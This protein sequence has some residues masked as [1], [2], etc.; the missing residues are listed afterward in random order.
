MKAVLH[1]RAGPNFRALI[2]S[3]RGVAEIVV[4]DPAASAEFAR[5]MAEAEIL[6]HVLSPVT[7][8][9]MD[10]APH[11]MLVQKIG[12]GVD[13]IDRVHA[14]RRGIAVCNMPGTNTAAVAEMTLSLI[15]ACLR[16]LTELSQA[17]RSGQGW[18]IS[19]S[20]GDGVGELAG[21]T[22]G[23]V[24]YGAVARRLVPV[25]EALGAHPVVHGRRPNS[26]G[27]PLLPLDELLAKSDIVS[28]HLPATE[29]TAGIIDSRRI[30]LMKP[31]AILVNT[32]RGSLVDEVALAHALATGHLSAAGLDVFAQ[33]PPPPGNPLL[34]LSNVVATPHI[35]WLTQG[36][37]ARSLE[38]VNENAARLAA[39]RELLH[40]VC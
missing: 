19:N 7:A 36:T 12:V 15:L 1:Y 22:V 28:L 37:L 14:Q 32:A 18:A 33:E 4:V 9:I 6:L 34:E 8:E 5:Q 39:G 24:G 16:R 23:L 21:R 30:A 25:L 13:A 17:T 40:R 38:V 11:L 2:E 26:G 10:L 35:A 3:H 20:L 27:V 29:A 31:G